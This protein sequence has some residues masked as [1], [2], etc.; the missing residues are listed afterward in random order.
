MFQKS[1]TYGKKTQ[2][3]VLLMQSWVRGWV[4]ANHTTWI[5][6]NENTPSKNV[7]SGHILLFGGGNLPS[8][9]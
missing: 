7:E 4:W 2:I 9:F 5:K 3:C 8:Y 1:I 6:I